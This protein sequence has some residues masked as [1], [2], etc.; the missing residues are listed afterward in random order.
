MTFSK[1]EAK[2]DVELQNQLK[3]SA[4]D[5]IIIDSHNID[6]IIKNTE[7]IS[8][9]ETITIH[10]FQNVSIS[11][12]NLWLKHLNNHDLIIIDEEQQTLSRDIFILENGTL[13]TVF[14]NVNLEKYQTYTFTLFYSLNRNIEKFE[15]K[16]SY[17]LF[18][19]T[20]YISFLTLDQTLRVR[21]PEDSHV[22]VFPSKTGTPSYT[23]ESGTSVPSGGYVFIV[24]T[25][26][27][28]QTL[29][30]QDFWV[31]FDESEG[32]ISALW[33]IVGLSLGIILGAVSVFW[34][35][36]R[37]ESKAIERIGKIFLSDDQKFILKTILNNEGTITQKELIE[38][39][40]FTKSKISRNL[41]PLEEYGLIQKEKWGREYKCWLTE[42]GR[43]VIE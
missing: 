7:D 12:I 13:V 23:P 39:T 10:N 3:I 26:N 6:I 43:K 1:I 33:I 37:R 18:H 21:L 16:D 2:D 4:E 36:K 17:Y 28:L 35:M 19:F 20:S 9:N 32:G 40:N 15:G 11:Q 30:Y 25:F 14:F 38:S 5:T 34:W 42:M 8:I 41:F 24:W 31:F 22:H 27:N 29:T